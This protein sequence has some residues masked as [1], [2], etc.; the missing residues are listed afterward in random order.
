MPVTSPLAPTARSAWSRGESRYWPGE[1]VAPG[2][3]HEAGSW[4]VT[5]AAVPHSRL[6]DAWAYRLDTEQGSVAYSGDTA[7]SDELIR[8]AQGADLLIHECTATEAIIREKGLEDLH[9]SSST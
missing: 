2:V 5:A 9:T 1:L 3:V 4:K 8:L 7:P 6:L